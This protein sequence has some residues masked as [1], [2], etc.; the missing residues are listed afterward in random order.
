MKTI[1]SLAVASLLAMS[2]L[3]QNQP[4]TSEMDPE[5]AELL[6]TNP[7]PPGYPTRL[8]YVRSF[9]NQND[10]HKAYRS[11]QLTKGEAM[12]A[13]RTLEAMASFDTYG[14]VIDQDSRPVA[15]VQVLSH[16]MKGLGDYKECDTTTDAKGLFHYTGLHGMA[17]IFHFNKEGYE[18]NERLL[19]QRPDNYLP[20]PKNPLIIQMW[21]LR[22][23]E[24]M[25]HVQINSSVPC[26][27]S[28]E[29]F[30]LLTR[31]WNGTNPDGL[32]ANGDLII[33][34]TR[35]PFILNARERF[36]PF[37]WSVTLAITNGGLQETTNSYPYD[38]PVEGY[39]PMITLEFPTNMVEWKHEF[40][41]A[42]FFKA[43]NGQIYGRMTLHID[44]SRP[45]P[46]TY[47]DG[48]IFA[49]PAG[50]RNLE[51]DPNKQIMR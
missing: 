14:K 27:G 50:S 12:I 47:F 46:P 9:A 11:G 32:P 7:P 30:D 19:P 35:N 49:N 34:L 51:F 6:S 45:Q 3:A 36:K 4:G 23:A 41:R 10:I 44:A 1:L 5:I 33:N 31:R 29:R 17:L 42:Y 43:Q 16:L 22:G 48:E 28:I 24:P 39:Q 8:N 21:K 13:T 15:G 38:A 40:K 20:D 26:D 2:A 18:F 37:N 25:K